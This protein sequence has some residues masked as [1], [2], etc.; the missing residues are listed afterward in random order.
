MI[1]AHELTILV[2]AVALICVISMA[3]YL[4]GEKTRKR[5]DELERRVALISSASETEP[6][7]Q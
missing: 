5:V 6:F 7:R 4:Q 3:L 1:T 2:A